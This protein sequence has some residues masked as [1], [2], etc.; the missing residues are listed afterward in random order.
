M[1]AIYTNAIS[2][3]RLYRHE[4]FKVTHINPPNRTGSKK[5][6]LQKTQME[7][8]AIEKQ[9]SLYYKNGSTFRISLV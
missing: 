1:A 8:V 7:T 2:Q 5:F 9:R 6:E 3:Q 4:S